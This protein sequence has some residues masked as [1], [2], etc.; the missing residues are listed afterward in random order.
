[1]CTGISNRINNY[2][3][4][5]GHTLG[6]TGS[7]RSM[8]NRALIEDMC[9]D[10][11]FYNAVEMLNLES[12]AFICP[13]GLPSEVK[14][15]IMNMY[16]ELDM[17]N[18]EATRYENMALAYAKNIL[19]E[20]DVGYVSGEE[21]IKNLKTVPSVGNITALVWLSEVVTP[22]RF[23]TVKHL[24]AYC[25]CD[26]SLKV[27]A[28]KVTSRV[29]RKGNNKLHY[30]LTKVAG[31][32]INR[33]SEAFGKWGYQIFKKHTKGGYKKACGA[34]A[35]RIATSM[36]Y[37]HKKN[38]PFSYEKYNFYK[39]DVPM[40]QVTDMGLSKRLVNLLEANRILDSKTLMEEYNTGRIYSIRGFGRKALDEIN[41]WLK[42][43]KI[44]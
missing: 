33:H 7:V 6:S 27:S 15:L 39:F 13:E 12:G 35:R 44:F 37:V 3:L 23:E 1:M 41:T 31:T 9:S 18:V 40:K 26:P 42:N 5:F 17:H 38:E 24:S 28:D 29:R 10:N 11:F 19:W 20:T 22:L 43:N 34:V 30:Q 2:V 25:G 8:K 16:E 21:L 4:R 32:C 14:Q 36:Y